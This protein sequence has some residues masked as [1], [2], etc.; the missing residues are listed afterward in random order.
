MQSGIGVRIDFVIWLF[1]GVCRI[2]GVQLVSDD[3]CYYYDRDYD[4]DSNYDYD[5]YPC[6]VA[7]LYFMAKKKNG[8]AAV[9]R[10]C[11]ALNIVKRVETTLK[12]QH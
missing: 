11:Q 8:A 6:S 4:Y 9:R 5:Y 1:A 10:A 12:W 7:K 3:Y 2:Y